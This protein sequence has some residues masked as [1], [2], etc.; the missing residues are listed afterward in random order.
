ML[1]SVF[2]L[3]GGLIALSIALW[4]F[5]REESPTAAEK[6]HGIK[7]NLGKALRTF[8]LATSDAQ[9]LLM[10]AYGVNFYL[11]QLCTISAYHYSVVIH[12]GLISC[13]TFL[14]VIAL[15][16]EYWK[17]PFSATLRTIVMVVIFTVLGVLLNHQTTRVQSPE[18][19]PPNSRKDSTVLLPMSCFLDPQFKDIYS[20]LASSVREEIGSPVSTWQSWQFPLWIVLL[21]G[22]VLG[23]IRSLIQLRRDPAKNRESHRLWNSMVILFYKGLAWAISMIMIIIAWAHIYSLRSWVGRSGWIEPGRIPNPENDWL[24]NGQI[25]PMLQLLM[26]C[27]FISNEF[28][29]KSHPPTTS[30]AQSRVD[31]NIPLGGLQSHQ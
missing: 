13:A 8:L 2:L 10:L 24:G 19:Q 11:V 17:A 28:E 18:Y 29:L 22:F 12:M 5:V 7:A 15:V 27:I 21:I 25:L 9:M 23:I 14:I 1:T 30:E 3:V 16:S 4:E 26:I 31:P 20:S 6:R